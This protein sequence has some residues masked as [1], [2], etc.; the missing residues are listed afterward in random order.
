MLSMLRLRSK[1][2]SYQ[3]WLP[4]GRPRRKKRQGSR[5]SG[6]RSSICRQGFSKKSKRSSTARET[7]QLPWTEFAWNCIWQKFY[8]QPFLKAPVFLN[9][10]TKVHE[11]LQASPEKQRRAVWILLCGLHSL[12]R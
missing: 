10:K 8:K 3:N 12:S 11:L 1:Q 9:R 7:V 2:G 5:I 4:T 6:R